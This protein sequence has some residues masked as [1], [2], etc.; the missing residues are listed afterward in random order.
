MTVDLHGLDHLDHFAERM[1]AAAGVK[2]AMRAAG[3]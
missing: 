3:L 2:A 1:N